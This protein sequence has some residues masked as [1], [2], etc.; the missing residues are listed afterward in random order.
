[1][2]LPV[3][4]MIITIAS[5]F[6]VHSEEYKFLLDAHHHDRELTDIFTDFPGMTFKIVK[7]DVYYMG[8]GEYIGAF[9]FALV[10]ID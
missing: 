8:K 3:H 2:K 7:H 10:S 9:G 5:E 4:K 6:E 1:M